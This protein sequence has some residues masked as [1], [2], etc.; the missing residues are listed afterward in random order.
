MASQITTE[1]ARSFMCA[2]PGSDPD[3]KET[4][5]RWAKHKP[6]ELLPAR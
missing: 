4:I 6:E 2:V 5:V 1:Q 3:A